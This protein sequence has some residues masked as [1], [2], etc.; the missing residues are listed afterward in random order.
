MLSLW[1]KGWV[2]QKI[3]KV[4]DTSFELAQENLI[5]YFVMSDLNWFLIGNIFHSNL[6][7]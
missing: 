3:E 1:M 2:L 4:P 6:S 7:Y 5:V